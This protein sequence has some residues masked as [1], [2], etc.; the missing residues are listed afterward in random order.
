MEDDHREVRIQDEDPIRCDGAHVEQHRLGGTVE[1]ICHQR[2]LDHDQG[3]EDVLAPQNHAVVRGLVRRVV[4]H[5][6][7]LGPAQ[8]EHE[9]GVDGELGH[10]LERCWVILA[11]VTE[12]LAQ[13]DERTIKPPGRRGA[14]ELILR[15][16]L[17][18]ELPGDERRASLLVETRRDVVDVGTLRPPPCGR[19]D[20]QA[21]LPARHR[22][23]G[24]KLQEELLRLLLG[25]RLRPVLSVAPVCGLKEHRKAGVIAQRAQ[26]PR[27]CSPAAHGRIRDGSREGLLVQRRARPN[28]T[29]GLD[30]ARGDHLEDAPAAHPERIL[31][32]GGKH[33][34]K[35]RLE[36]RVGK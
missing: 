9:L 22:A 18:R 20:P 31:P 3:V 27:G 7:K 29:R 28:A 6:D 19:C 33:P 2:G 1:R 30:V 17:P 8:V 24:D 25:R 14:I 35:R 36:H 5:L 10:E 4:E 16:H 23:H 12:P 21:R 34:R 11:V 26:L 32:F 15:L 13:A